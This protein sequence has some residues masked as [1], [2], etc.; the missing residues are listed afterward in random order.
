M[1]VKKQNFYGAYFAI[2]RHQNKLYQIGQGLILA[3]M[4]ELLFYSHAF[5]T[6]IVLTPLQLKLLQFPKYAQLSDF[7][8]IMPNSFFLQ[9]L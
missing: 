6:W 2:A 8:K 9:L 3:L 1:I 4:R 5:I 7:R